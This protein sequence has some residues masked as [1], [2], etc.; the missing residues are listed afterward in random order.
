MRWIRNLIASLVLVWV[1]GG[2]LK[3]PEFS[4]VPQISLQRLNFV[5]GASL[6]S[7]DSLIV[8]LNFSD[9]DGDLGLGTDETAIYLSSTD[10][11]DLS[12]PYYFVFNTQQPSTW[13]Y[14]HSNSLTAPSLPSG[15]QYVNLAS[16][17]TYKTIAP[18]DTLPA[19]SCRA[20]EYR[21]SLSSSVPKDTLYI[22]NNPHNNNIF[23]AIY[24]KNADGTYTYLDIVNYANA[25]FSKSCTPNYLNGR[26]PILSSDL[27]KKAP[28]QGTL[29]YKITELGF[30]QLLHGLPSPTHTIRLQV[31]ITDRALH[32]SNVVTSSDLTIN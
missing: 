21:D 29:T 22:Q 6:I 25:S 18:F 2:C 31:Y 27:G 13:Y 12:T 3:Q 32:T 11:I 24:Y 16:T 14:T 7:P 4:I 19:L 23:V 17:R 9:G 28:I 30:F 5:R 26:F 10:S 15:Y 20:W 1:I 8:S